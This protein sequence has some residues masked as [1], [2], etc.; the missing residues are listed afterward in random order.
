[1]IRLMAVLSIL[2]FGVGTAVAEDAGRSGNKPAPVQTKPKNSASESKEA[3]P[4][5]RDRKKAGQDSIGKILDPIRHV[6][7]KI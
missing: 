5:N 3:L 7:T 4:S 1:M 2:I 6:D